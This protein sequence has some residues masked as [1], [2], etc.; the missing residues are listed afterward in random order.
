MCSLWVVNS[1]LYIS[2]YDE[3]AH[4]PVLRPQSAGSETGR[5]LHM[6]NGLSDGTWGFR[7]PTRGPR[8]VVWAALRL[9]A[10]SPT[11]A[12]AAGRTG[13]EELG[14]SW[15]L[16]D[17]VLPDA[18]LIALGPH[19]TQQARPPDGRVLDAATRFHRPTTNRNSAP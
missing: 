5:V 4:Q 18:L 3:S 17:P 10:E 6:I 12:H 11:T 16:A 1:R 15:D 14:E 7:P 8:R 2:M 13:T 9:D 19:L